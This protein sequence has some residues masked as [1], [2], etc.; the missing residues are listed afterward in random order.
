MIA[1]RAEPFRIQTKTTRRQPKFTLGK[2][3][4]MSSGMLNKINF[5]LFIEV[6]V[7]SQPEWMRPTG[8]LLPWK[9]PSFSSTG[10]R[11]PNLCHGPLSVVRLSVRALTFSLNIFFS[12]TTYRIL[13][14]FHRNV[15]TMVLFRFLEII[16]FL[17]KP[18]LPWQQNW[19][20]FEIF[21]NLLVRNNKA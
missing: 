11:P 6:R 5:Q 4:E 9:V 12:E 10:R 16:W 3:Q 13:M 8:A 20:F 1:F 2:C 14:K 17:Q 19:I 21:E 7:Y 15:P 18:W